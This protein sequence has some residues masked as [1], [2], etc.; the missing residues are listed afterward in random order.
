MTDQLTQQDIPVISVK[1]HICIV[2]SLFMADELLTL[3]LPNETAA[4]VCVLFFVLFFL[5]NNL[6]IGCNWH[7]HITSA[8]THSETL[9]QF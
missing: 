4:N 2:R 1:D 9:K 6:L 8:E 3:S 5:F 7:C